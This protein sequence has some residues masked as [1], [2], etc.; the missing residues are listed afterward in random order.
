MDCLHVCAEDGD[1]YK[2]R[3]AE[4]KMFWVALP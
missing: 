4:L 3:V 2:Q 1:V